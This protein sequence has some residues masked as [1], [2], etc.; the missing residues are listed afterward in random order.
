L[1]QLAETLDLTGISRVL[2]DNFSII[3]LVQ[4]V[5]LTNNKLPLEASGN[6]N[7]CNNL[8]STNSPV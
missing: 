6:I 7:A 8:E 5:K 1:V 4:A 2:C 3:D